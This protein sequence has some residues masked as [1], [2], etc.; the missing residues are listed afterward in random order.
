MAQIEMRISASDKTVKGM[1][2]TATDNAQEISDTAQIL[3]FQ[4]AEELNPAALKTIEE[5]Q[6]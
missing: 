5:G 4:L 6:A 2:E 1:R 3:F